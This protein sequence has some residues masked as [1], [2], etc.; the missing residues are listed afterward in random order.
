M[1]PSENITQYDI[2]KSNRNLE[3]SP[4]FLFY[5]FEKLKPKEI[6][7]SLRFHK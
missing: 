1:T 6:Q 4:N 2:L 3:I 7:A 5:R